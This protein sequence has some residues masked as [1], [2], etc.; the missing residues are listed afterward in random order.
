M[1][2]TLLFSFVFSY[3]VANL[4]A[5]SSQEQLVYHY[6]ASK[7]AYET[8]E[9]DKFLMHLKKADS[10]SPSHHTITYN[11]AAAYALNH[12]P[13]KSAVMLKRAVLMNS[14]LFPSEDIDFESIRTTE[15][16]KE[17]EYL[18]LELDKTVEQSTV[19]YSIDELDLHPES[20]AFNPKNESFLISSV[21]KGKIMSYRPTSGVY[22]EWIAAGTDSLWA[23]MGIKVDA[24]NNEL[25]VC[26][27]A[28]PEMILYDSTLE[29]KTAIHQYDLT[30]KKLLQ[31]Y[32]LSGGHWFGDLVIHPSG[33][34]YVSDSRVPIIYKIDRKTNQLSV[35]KDFTNELFNLQGIDFDSKGTTLFIADYKTGIYRYD[36]GTQQLDFLT[37]PASMITKGV[38]GL[39]FYQ[40]NLIAIQNGVR[41]F[42]VCRFKLNEKLTAI[43]DYEYL[44]KGRAELDEP[45]LGV[46]VEDD[47]YYI[48]NSPWGK[49]NKEKHLMVDKDFKNIVLKYSLK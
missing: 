43:I 23:T 47:F 41:P 31:R 46:I 20:I 8:K 32:E 49:Y 27:T 36:L 44:D 16:Y 6:N 33:D 14:K 15:A 4:F 18:K 22:E 28:T 40:D 48:A 5:Q 2:R 35:F 17:I 21:H 24:K 12:Q 25:W 11:L 30:T 42:R 9:F 1:K 19:A 45:T 7:A 13:E 37:H 26:S 39:Y 10:I 3:I 38:D 34:V 29:G